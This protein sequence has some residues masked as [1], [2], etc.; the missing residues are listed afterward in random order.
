MSNREDPEEG[1]GGSEIRETEVDTTLTRSK[2]LHRLDL[3]HSETRQRTDLDNRYDPDDLHDIEHG[4]DEIIWMREIG[5]EDP[6]A[7]PIDDS[8][9]AK[10]EE[11]EEEKEE[12][13]EEEE[14]EEEEGRDEIDFLCWFFSSIM[15]FV[16]L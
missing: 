2:T 8:E 1:D 12:E 11:E 15:N 6:S 14:E 13:K 16:F 10:E 4:E 3:I 9:G 5:S 7:P